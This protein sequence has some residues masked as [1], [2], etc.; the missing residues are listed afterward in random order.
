MSRQTKLSRL[1][2]IEGFDDPMDLLES[3]GYDSVMPGM[4][5]NDGCTY[6]YDGL[7]PDGTADCPDCG[8]HSVESA[9]LLAGLI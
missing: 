3:V 9:L 1:A 7:E 8:T 4:C 2:R 5:T 6:Y